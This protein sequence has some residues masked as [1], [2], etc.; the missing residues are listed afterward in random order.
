VT[1]FAASALPLLL[2]PFFPAASF[3]LPLAKRSPQLGDPSLLF[4]GLLPPHALGFLAGLF[5]AAGVFSSP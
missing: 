1:D 2:G 5:L 4:A 3:V